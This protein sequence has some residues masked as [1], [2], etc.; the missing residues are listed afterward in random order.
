MR[1]TI[2]ISHATPSDNIFATWLA[3]KLEL[4]GYKVWV[5]INNLKPSVD[6]WNTIDF[7]IRDDAVK[8]IFVLS[9]VSINPNRDGVQKELAVADKVRRQFANFIVPVR[10]DDVNYNDL[11]VEVLRLN[12]IDFY[13][14][15]AKGLDSL[16]KYLEDE[17]IP[18]LAPSTVSQ[19]YID[20]WT[21]SQSKIRSQI[22]DNEDEYCSNLFEVELPPSVFIYKREDV[23]E[24]L[25]ARHIPM[26][27][28]KKVVITFACNKCIC[29]WCSRSVD[30]IDLNTKDVIQNCFTPKTYLGETV[31]NLSRDVISVINWMI[32][33]MFY[34]HALRRYKS[35][36]VKTSRNV[37]YF[38][39]GIKS[40]RDKKSRE[41]AL[42][43]TYKHIKKWHFGLSGYY[44]QYPLS[45][46]ILKWHLIF[47]DEKGYVLPDA[48]QI[49]ARRSKGKLM[50][51]RQ[52][53][54]WLQ[55]SMFYLSNGTSHIFYT[56]CCEE[57]AMYIS[58]ESVRFISEK[59][60]IEPYV[61]KQAGED[62]DE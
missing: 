13:N 39:Y 21:S 55:A 34:K 17:S 56:D 6:F 27:K 31:S 19:R 61:I 42:S 23:E 24:A 35:D 2:F 45:G 43:G 44:T 16:L 53:K 15:W 3:T 8:F 28:N 11:P 18:K 38:P 47:T 41:K 12:V 60:Y 10:I 33:E 40:K 26:K 49:S 9:N 30:Y 59:S 46:I 48:S 32:G 29:E 4:C 1:D 25:R 51:N 37:Y 22:I 62:N 58:S 54:E 36:S 14:D 5:D 7:T 57:N 52:W 50:F 20:R